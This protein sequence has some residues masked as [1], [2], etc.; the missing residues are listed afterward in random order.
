MVFYP[1]HGAIAILNADI[2]FSS[3]ANKLNRPK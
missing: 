2:K 1:A 3:S